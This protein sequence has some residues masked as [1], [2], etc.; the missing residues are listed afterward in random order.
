MEVHALDL[1]DILKPEIIQNK[2]Q[3][4]ILLGGEK[5]NY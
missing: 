3:P 5:N 4:W 1:I 2:W